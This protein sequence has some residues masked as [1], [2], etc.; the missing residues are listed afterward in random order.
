MKIS[1]FIKFEIISS[2]IISE[3][4]VY[5]KNYKLKIMFLI[6]IKLF[7]LLFPYQ[8]N[9]SDIQCEIHVLTS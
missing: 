9:H 2:I 7:L 4:K 3:I 1:H 5:Q 8:F 6:Y